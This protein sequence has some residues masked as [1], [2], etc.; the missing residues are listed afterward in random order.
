M[1]DNTNSG[2]LFKNDKREKET[3]PQYKGSVDVEGKEYWVSSWVNESKNGAK[4][5]SLKLTAKEEQVQQPVQQVQQAT[6][7]SFDDDLPF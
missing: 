2:A 5:F 7:E 1:Y 3:Q 4:Y 6:P